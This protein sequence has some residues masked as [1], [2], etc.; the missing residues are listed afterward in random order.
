MLVRWTLDDK[1]RDY[2]APVSEKPPLLVKSHGSPTSAT[3]SSLKFSIANCDRQF[4]DVYDLPNG[5]G[6]WSVSG[7]I[8]AGRIPTPEESSLDGSNC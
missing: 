8:W 5:I 3:S 4:L 6:V 2:T 1:N 7:I